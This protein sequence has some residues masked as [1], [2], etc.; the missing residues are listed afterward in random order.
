MPGNGAYGW[1]GEY[2]RFFFGADNHE[3]LVGGR[4]LGASAD[5]NDYG[6][7]GWEGTARLRF[8]LPCGFELASFA[9][10]TRENYNGPATVL[11]TRERRDGACIA[12]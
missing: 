3:L 8:K 10:C 5:R 2:V 1:I 12:Y 6:Y 9:S 7:S 4:F 11:E